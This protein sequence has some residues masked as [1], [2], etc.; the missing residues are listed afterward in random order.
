MLE[1][2][3]IIDFTRLLPGPVATHLLA[4]M[5][6]EVIKIESPKRQDYARIGLNPVDGASLMFH[7]LNHLKDLRSIDYEREKGKAEILEL[8]AS[9]DAVIEQFRP[10]AM[11][12]WGLDHESL[13]AIK[14]DLVYISL[15]GYGQ[16]GPFAHMAGH[17]INYLAYSGI[18]DLNRDETGRPVLPG[19]QFA[20][21]S[22]AY[23]AVMSLQGALLQQKITGQGSY[24]EVAMTDAVLP[25]LTF[26]YNLEASGMPQ[27]FNFL[28]GTTA[29]NYGLYECADGK[30][31]AV[32]AL[33]TKFWNRLCL[34][35]DRPDWQRNNQLELMVQQFP[36]KEVEELFLSQ[37][38]QHWLEVLEKEEVCVS[39]V[40]KLGE[41][42]N[43][44][45]HQA[46]E[47]FGTFLSPKGKE[48]KEMG[49]VWREG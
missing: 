10:G 36:R 34:L 2:I 26:P 9:A 11:A 47:N 13:K 37:D 29:V 4:Q 44:P 40:L 27:S 6:A 33:E 3:R 38:R 30:F 22:G 7:Q 46:R 5:G 45:Y 49:K 17:D 16:T 31:L 42:E 8:V 23:L 28:N 41:L 24:V 21:I 39:P 14:S 20:D 43:H 1:G 48:L 35:I 25:F 12:A 18:L 15:T 32:G 19:V